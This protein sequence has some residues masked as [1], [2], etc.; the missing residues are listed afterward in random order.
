M[1]SLVATDKQKPRYYTQARRR[2][3]TKS[4]TRADTN[5]WT[6]TRT[7]ANKTL[8]IPTD[9]RFNGFVRGRRCRPWRTS[10]IAGRI[11]SACFGTQL[12]TA[13]F[14]HPDALQAADNVGFRRAY[15]LH[16]QTTLGVVFSRA[17]VFCTFDALLADARAA[18][19][20]SRR[21][22]FC[23][24]QPLRSVRLCVLATYAYARWQ[25][26]AHARGRAS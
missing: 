8:P 25:R 21:A 12:A 10:V 14:D 6:H 3:R 2:R 9:A 1:R 18:V 4:V 17:R 24:R 5:T 16:D 26:A 13:C 15:A 20:C 7:L 11:V 22:R 23:P 19:P